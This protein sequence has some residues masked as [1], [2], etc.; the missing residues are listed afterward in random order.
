M[1]ATPATAG[2]DSVKVRAFEAADEPRVLEVLK[3]A[4]GAWPGDIESGAP[5]EFLHWKHMRSPF[6][7]S[8]LM[9]AETDG[10]VVG[11]YAYMAWRFRAHGQIMKA[12]RG[13]D[14]AVHPAHRR[15]GVSLA[16]RAEPSFSGDVA[17]F[18]SNPNEP[19]RPGSLI[20]G[21]SRVDGLPRFAAPGGPM[22]ETIRR[23]RGRGSR[24]PERL[25]VEA[26]TTGE[27]LAD[28]AHVSALL[29]RARGPSDRLETAKDLDYL[30]WRYGRFEDYRAITTDAGEGA[31]GLAIFRPRR[32]GPF[33]VSDVC[34]LFVERND[35]RTARHLFRQVRR[36]A[37]ADFISCSFA[38]RRDAALFGFV[39]SPGGTVLMAAPL[40]QNLLPDPTRPASW[41]LSRGDLE[42]L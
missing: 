17:F 1:S 7:P 37:P 32:R 38:S 22:R 30:R 25:P 26:G 16:I 18:W 5:G 19:S 11:F 4:F 13:V 8:T 24:T 12:M 9:V 20:S 28:G 31:G 21:R 14:L 34:E 10:E 23:A 40:Q 39:Q 35:A 2:P 29:E 15:R 33:W 3:A 6:G 42:L 27:I 36:A 41:A